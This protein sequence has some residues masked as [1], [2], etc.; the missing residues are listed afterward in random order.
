MR[1]AFEE[2][3]VIAHSL[4]DLKPSEVPSDYNVKLTDY[5][6][7]GFKMNREKPRHDEKLHKQLKSMLDAGITELLRYCHPLYS[8]NSV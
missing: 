6:P 8:H 7:I 3:T 2:T 5:T 1:G 4:H